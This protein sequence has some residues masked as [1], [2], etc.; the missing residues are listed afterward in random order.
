MISSAASNVIGV[1]VADSNRM[2][3]QLLTNA[4]RR[5][6]EFE[7]ASCPA[8]IT[9]I[10]QS[11][12]STLPRVAL[13]T[14]NPGTISQTVVTLR[15]FHLSHPGI[16]KVLLVDS[17]DRELVISAFRSGTRGIFPITD[18][19]LRQLC[20]CILRVAAGQ[21]WANTEQLNY[22]MDAIS[23]VPSMRVLNTK[24]A[25]L[26]TP[27]EEQVVALVVEGM[28]NRLI[29]RELNLSEHTIKKYLF[30]IFEKLGIS[31]RVELVLYALS[32]GEP[33]HAEWIAA[34]QI[35]PVA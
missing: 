20:K 31:S 15:N 23:E 3:A 7:V 11:V 1:L 9:S 6:P 13:V 12:A 18:A 28:G 25:S 8:E 16:A 26:L 14:L 22:I 10:L 4:L 34:G 21:I 27:R 35:P 2:Q 29:A 5:R 24:G 17:C 33:R 19:D 30:R 32:N